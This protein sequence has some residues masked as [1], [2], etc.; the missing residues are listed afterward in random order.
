[1]AAIDDQQL[2]ATARTSGDRCYDPE[3][4][5]LLLPPSQF[6]VHTALRD[7]L[8]HPYRESATYA[9]A[10]LESDRAD[11][12]CDVLRQVITGQDTD[13]DSP[14]CGV[15]SYYAE[16]PLGAMRRPDHNWADFL[17]QELALVEYNSPTYWLVTITAMSAISQLID[18]ADAART[19]TGLVELLWRH[20]AARWHVPTGQLAGPMSRAYSNDTAESPA[21]LGFLTKAVDTRPPFDLASW[22]DANDPACH[23][24]LVATALLRPQAPS[25]VVN[26]LTTL[27]DPVE[28]REL[29]R[30]EEPHQVGTTWLD[31]TH[32]VGS[33][34]RADMW[35][36]RRNLMGY[37]SLPGDQ[38]WK[39]A[40]RYVRLRLLKDD[41]DF[42][43]GDFS[44]V[45]HRNHVLWQI[46]IASPGGDRHVHRDVIHAGDP[47][48][49]STLR[50][51]FELHTG[52]S[53]DIH[54][55]GSPAVPGDGF[56]IGDT[57][58]VQTGDVGIL[59][60]PTAGT[61]AATG[62]LRCAGEELYV[63]VDLVHS[64]RPI[65]LDLTTLET[66][67]V[68]GAF[69]LGPADVIARTAAV[70]TAVSESA[71]TDTDT[72]SQRWQPDARL[73]LTGR[74]RVGTRTEHSAAYRAAING[75]PPPEPRL[76]DTVNQLPE[77]V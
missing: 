77:E 67:Y 25:D 39:Q 45:Q 72:V 19:A 73:D 44:S 36:Q 52:A 71:D 51:R 61:R 59:I 33:V 47:I 3:A 12:A 48:R 60:R 53:S 20:F 29:F 11:L 74:A 56:E 57:V 8:V 23:L 50:A 17:G 34:S 21:L 54:I 76:A 16:E 22:E 32:A 1:M 35:L 7:G 42:V 66:A 40:A 64:D 6:S 13:P 46:G 14:T 62:R 24:G 27:A 9:L 38:P 26:R 10:L 28:R 65:D 70:S 43:S 4:R 49:L 75:A 69:A 41:V 18:D 15:W 2:L 68:A 5:L 30:V 37:W 31:H 63:D 55:N 58:T